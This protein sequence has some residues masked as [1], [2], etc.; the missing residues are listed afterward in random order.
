MYT[1]MQ[2]RFLSLVSRSLFAGSGRWSQRCSSAVQY[3]HQAETPCSLSVHPK[4]IK[5]YLGVLLV[6][7]TWNK[8]L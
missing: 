4:G 7:A 5:D 3:Q 6:E 2:V 8:C 1:F